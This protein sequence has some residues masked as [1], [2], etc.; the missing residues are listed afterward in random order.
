VLESDGCQQDF[1]CIYCSVFVTILYSARAYLSMYLYFVSSRPCTTRVATDL[2]QSY[3]HHVQDVVG[4][5]TVTDR[6]VH[7][8]ARDGAI[9]QRHCT[10]FGRLR[11]AMR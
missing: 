6:R 10:V 2:F 3:V 9:K 11:I 4:K 1:L 7:H 8:V 5:M